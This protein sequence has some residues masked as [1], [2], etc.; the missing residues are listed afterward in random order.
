M[1]AEKSETIYAFERLSVA[2]LAKRVP[3]RCPVCSSTQVSL[4]GH[5]AQY[6]DVVFYGARLE[7]V[8]VGDEGD[9]F[10]ISRWSC[11]ECDEVM[12]LETVFIIGP[13]EVV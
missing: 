2:E 9:D 12:D 5:W 7:V 1:S 6:A 8:H 4:S 10:F 13:E 3:Q 11:D